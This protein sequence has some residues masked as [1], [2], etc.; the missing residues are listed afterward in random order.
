MACSR[1]ARASVFTNAGFKGWIDDFKVIARKLDPETACNHAGGTLIGLPAGYTGEHTH[2]ANWFPASTHQAI[3][4]RLHNSGETAYAAYAN[5]YDHGK[6]NG[7]HLGNLPAGTASLR[8]AIHFPEGPFYHNTPRP[9]STQNQFCIT[10]HSAP[11]ANENTHAVA[12]KNGLTMEALM[13]RPVN[14]V[15]DLRRLPSQPPAV[16]TGECHRGHV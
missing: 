13:L 12:F 8:D 7:A 16:V 4:N 11:S 1:S 5:H 15:Q 2:F 14:A 10:C 6:D 3:S 9:D